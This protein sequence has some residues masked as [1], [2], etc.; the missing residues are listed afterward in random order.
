MGWV[1][2]RG[3]HRAGG[4]GQGWG[5]VGSGPG[6]G[7]VLGCFARGSSRVSGQLGEGHIVILGGSV[8]GVSDP[9]TLSSAACGSEMPEPLSL[10]LQDGRVGVWVSVGALLRPVAHILGPFRVPLGPAWPHSHFPGAGQGPRPLPTPLSSNECRAGGARSPWRPSSRREVMWCRLCGVVFCPFTRTHPG[11]PAFL[12]AGRRCRRVRAGD[13][14]VD[15]GLRFWVSTVIPSGTR[16]PSSS[17]GSGDTP[18]ARQ[19]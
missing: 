3:R 7:A 12:H 6:L 15:S 9:V 19:R 16:E 8:L 10:G 11:G 2:V 17:L 5:G 18:G 4:T 14:L 1:V 13:R